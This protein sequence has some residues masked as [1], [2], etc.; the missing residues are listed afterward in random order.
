MSLRFSCVAPGMERYS[1]DL[2]RAVK[3]RECAL[4]EGFGDVL[5]L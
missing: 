5:G 3:N 1:I 4:E 2:L